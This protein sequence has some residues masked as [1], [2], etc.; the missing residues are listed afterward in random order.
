MRG[1]LSGSE[2]RRPSSGYGLEENVAK[3]PH[4][5]MPTNW[6]VQDDG[7]RDVPS[8]YPLEQSSLTLNN[9]KPSEIASRISDCCRVMSVQAAFDND[10]VSTHIR[11]LSVPC[12]IFFNIER[13][14]SS[15]SLL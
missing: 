2:K 7:L 13:N 5:E 3:K 11:S 10:L 15:Y 9:V 14:V 8:F 1:P 6:V 4:N 12:L